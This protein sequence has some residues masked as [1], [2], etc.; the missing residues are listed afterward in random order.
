M[1][2]A[3]QKAARA[4]DTINRING[5]STLGSNRRTLVCIASEYQPNATM[6]VRRYNA[7]GSTQSSGTGATSVERY[8]VTPSINVEGAND[9][10]SHRTRVAAVIGSAGCAAFSCGVMSDV[11]DCRS[12]LTAHAVSSAATTT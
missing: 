8:V 12:T 3:I 10:A 2:I 9:N 1:R 11:D 5:S 7:S 4:S 6:N